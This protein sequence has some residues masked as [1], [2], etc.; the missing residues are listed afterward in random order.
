MNFKNG[1]LSCAIFRKR[2]RDYWCGPCGATWCP[3]PCGDPLLRPPSGRK[4]WYTQQCSG[5][6]DN[7]VVAALNRS[8]AKMQWNLCFSFFFFSFGCYFFKMRTNSYARIPCS[9]FSLKEKEKTE[10]AYMGFALHGSLNPTLPAVRQIKAII[11]LPINLECDCG[12]GVVQHE[13]V[14]TQ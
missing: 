6:G 13:P 5:P 3:P 11:I 7:G 10:K 1:L 9:F 14:S 2:P 8:M 12:C 4:Q